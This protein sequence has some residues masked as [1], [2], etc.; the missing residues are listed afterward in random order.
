[1]ITCVSYALVVLT[2]QGSISLKNDPKTMKSDQKSLANFKAKTSFFF[3]NFDFPI[4]LLAATSRDRFRKP[5]TGMW[6]ELLEDL[7]LDEGDGPNLGASFFVGDAG[8]R[9]ARNGVKADHACSDRDF[10]SNVGVVFHT[11]E[12]YFLH[13]EP[14]VYTRNFE[15]SAYLGALSTEASEIL[16]LSPQI[17]TAREL[18]AR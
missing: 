7:D 3:D 15:P 17:C 10:A 13:E 5:R 6:D 11:P 16:R 4:I 14:M 8:G 18:T 2:N 9:A 12:E 1:M